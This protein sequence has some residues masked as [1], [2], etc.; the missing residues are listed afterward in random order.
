VCLEEVSA[1]QGVIHPGRCGVVVSISGSANP[2]SVA[3][4]APVTTSV[5]IVDRS[6]GAGR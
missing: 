6:P 5:A 2:V 4:S 3:S 1:Q